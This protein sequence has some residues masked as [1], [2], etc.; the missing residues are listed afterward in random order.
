MVVSEK[1]YEI[2]GIVRLLL[3]SSEIANDSFDALLDEFPEISIFAETYLCVVSK[4]FKVF[5]E[6]SKRI[7]D[8]IL[9]MRF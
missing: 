9:K 7:L 4:I 3:P 1:D 8:R 6:I 2:R 5:I